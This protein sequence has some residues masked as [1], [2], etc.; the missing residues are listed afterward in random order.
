MRSLNLF[1]SKC[2]LQWPFK[3]LGQWFPPLFS[4]FWIL[5]ELSQ[6]YFTLIHCCWIPFTVGYPSLYS[7]ILGFQGYHWFHLFAPLSTRT[8]VVSATLVAGPFPILHYFSLLR[9]PLQKPLV[10]FP[11]LENPRGLAFDLSFFKTSRFHFFRPTFWLLSPLSFF[12][13]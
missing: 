4:S 11:I 2:V 5:I 1:K 6:G 9:F 3:D 8:N 13:K 12:P 7:V 10:D